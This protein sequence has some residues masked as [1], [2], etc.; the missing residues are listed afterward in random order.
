MSALC[1]ALL[2][3][4]DYFSLGKMSQ[5]KGTRLATN[6]LVKMQTSLIFWPT[7]SYAPNNEHREKVK[8]QANALALEHTTSHEVSTRMDGPTSCVL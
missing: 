3:D 4:D 2:S 7:L 8:T 1:D 5:L 6:R